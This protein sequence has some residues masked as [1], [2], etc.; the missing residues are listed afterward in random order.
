VEPFV[1]DKFLNRVREDNVSTFL[2]WTLHGL[3]GFESIDVKMHVRLEPF[4]VL[5]RSIVQR[6][7]ETCLQSTVYCSVSLIP[8]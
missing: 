2:T 8:R 7:K 4:L 6:L 1:S 3:D 5:V